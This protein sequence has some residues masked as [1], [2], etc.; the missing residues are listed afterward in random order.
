[1]LSIFLWMSLLI[2][3]DHDAGKDGG[4]EEKRE[5]EDEMVGWYH[6]LNGHEF[7]QTPEDSEG[8]GSL[9]CWSSWGC[10]EFDMTERLSN[11]SPLNSTSISIG[12]FIKPS[13]NYCEYTL[14]FFWS[15]VWYSFPEEVNIRLDLSGC[16]EDH[17]DKVHMTEKS[18]YFIN[19]LGPTGLTV[20]NM[21]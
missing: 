6:W 7:E 14:C 4:L 9:A 20:T 16:M 18:I 19:I 5:T 2:G 10:K 13:W 12:D 15:P 8:Q 11:N 3:K 21:F 17:Q 1:M